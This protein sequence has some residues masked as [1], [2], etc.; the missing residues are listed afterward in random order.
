M[1]P[2]LGT[3]QEQDRII[4]LYLNQQIKKVEQE[5]Q[6]RQNKLELEKQKVKMQVWD[7]LFKSEKDNLSKVSIQ[8]KIQPPQEL[9]QN[10][11]IMLSQHSEFLQET[12][13]NLKLNKPNNF[14]YEVEQS[15]AFDKSYQQD[16]SKLKNQSLTKSKQQSG[17][18]YHS[19]NNKSALRQRQLEES[20][21]QIERQ[22]FN[23]SYKQLDRSNFNDSQKQIDRNSFDTQKP[24]D[25]SDIQKTLDRSSF[26]ETQIRYEDEPFEQEIEEDINE[27]SDTQQE[28]YN[29]M[30]QYEQE[31]KE[32]QNSSDQE[33]RFVQFSI[34]FDEDEIE[35]KRKLEQMKKRKM[36][37]MEE[38]RVLRQNRK[39]TPTRQ[40]KE[41]SP[42]MPSASLKQFQ[43][44][45]IK[46]PFNADENNNRRSFNKDENQR[47]YENKYSRSPFHT[48]EQGRSFENEFTRIPQPSIP[49]P[50]T[51]LMQQRKNTSANRKSP[52]PVRE[53]QKVPVEAQL[54]SRDT[55]HFVDDKDRSISYDKAK[56]NNNK[57]MLKNAITFVCLA[58]DPNRREREHILSKLDLFDA[59]HYIILFKTFG[60]MV[61]YSVLQQDFKALYGFS[62]G[63]HPYLLFS[64]SKCPQLLTSEMVKIYF[65]YD[66]GAKSFKPIDGNKQFTIQVDAVQLRK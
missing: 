13:D 42:L 4:Q 2:E 46:S 25:R 66:S 14:T 65:K 20:A 22:S 16:A 57:N 30:D 9:N 32:D 34:K 59:E 17:F 60:R 31:M 45:Q 10:P 8:Y 41:V 51:P 23:D 54:Y 5:L 49:K 61:N 15:Q 18:E 33:Q 7:L 35:R 44:Q 1:L 53:P 28:M 36:L 6:Q 50:E 19:F 63:G 62:D 56:K 58:G 40:T 24:I 64:Q 55:A 43:K 48:E 11:F 39:E 3:S 21:K 38:L 47:V 29:K 26:N 27:A 12:Q 37:E 52:K